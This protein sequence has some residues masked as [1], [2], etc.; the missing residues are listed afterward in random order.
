M[1]LFSDIREQQIYRESGGDDLN[2]S[3]GALYSHLLSGLPNLPVN[4]R[5]CPACGELLASD[6]LNQ[7]MFQRHANDF[8]Y[9]RINDR[10]VLSG[11]EEAVSD[12]DTALQLVL[13]PEM[14][15][16]VTISIN[17][18]E[19]QSI[20]GM[21]SG[22]LSD[23]LQELHEGRMEI[24]VWAS[25]SHMQF[26]M[27]RKLQPSANIPE[28]DG[29]I[30]Q[31][32]RDLDLGIE[33]DWSALSNAIA[34]ASSRAE[35]ERRYLRGFYCYSLAMWLDRKQPYHDS[36]RTHIE[37]AFALLE[38]FDTTLALSALGILAMRMNQFA[39]LERCRLLT[40]LGLITRF[41][42]DRE[43]TPAD[44][45]SQTP[46]VNRDQALYID[47][48]LE[49]Y[50]EAVQAYYSNN[51]LLLSRCLNR[52]GELV[53][54]RDAYDTA[55]YQLLQARTLLR[56]GQTQEARICYRS[57]LNDPVFG[58]EAQEQLA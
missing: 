23:A 47:E 19:R 55:K 41:F 10:V 1:G 36:V 54:E 57:L 52:L 21:G 40:R 53:R 45:A 39:A 2:E 27:V 11:S 37:E 3:K 17:G 32:Q 15:A 34:A 44:G 25:G 31:Y 33:P 6:T 58:S 51:H 28:L 49:V 18:A 12:S 22:S 9:L 5:R 8:V 20:A 30:S 26:A 14:L 7:H 24:Q 29:T 50:L 35:S 38:P 4:L 13:P 46:A 43:L 16:K 56:L 48:Y 42:V